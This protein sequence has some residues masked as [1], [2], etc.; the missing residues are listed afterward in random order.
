VHDD[1]RQ[2]SAVLP[3]VLGTVGAVLAG[4]VVQRA[5]G[6]VPARGD[7]PARRPAART[8]RRAPVL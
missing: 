3:L 1:S 2:P 7:R 4:A 5:R 6:E 8:N